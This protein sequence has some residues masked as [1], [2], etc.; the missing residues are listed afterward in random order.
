MKRR[1]LELNFF[2]VCML[3]LTIAGCATHSHH[4][5]EPTLHPPKNADSVAAQALLEGNRLFADHQWTLAIK[6]Y[7]N[8]VQTQPSLAEAHYISTWRAGP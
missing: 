1:S 8:A 4:H 5:E 3:L 2:L 6:K 7:K